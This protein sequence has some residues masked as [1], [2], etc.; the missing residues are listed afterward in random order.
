MEVKFANWYEVSSVERTAYPV[1]AGH[2]DFDVVVVGGGLAGATAALELSRRGKSVALFEATQIGHGASGRNGG[3]VSSGFSETIEV[4]AQTVGIDNAR[5]LMDLS[6]KGAS[7]V[8]TAITEHKMKDVKPVPGWLSVQRHHDEITM[9]TR[10]AFSSEVIGRKLDYWST[11]KVR[12]HLQTERYFQGI[13]D[14][15]GFHIHPLNY[16]IQLVET[17]V[18]SGARVFENDPVIG[19]EKRP[20]GYEVKTDGGVVI[21][22]QLVVTGSAYLQRVFPEIKNL[23][24]PVATHVVVSDHLDAEEVGVISFNGAISDTRRAGD[25]FRLLPNDGKGIRLLWGGKIT[26]NPGPPHNLASTARRDIV[27][28]FPKLRGINIEY[29]WSGLMG[30]TLNKMPMIAEVQPGLWAC[31]GFGGHGINTTAMGG[32]LVARAI[33]NDDDVYRLFAPFIPKRGA[34]P[35]TKMLTQAAYWQMQ[36]RDRRDERR[37]R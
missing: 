6:R 25:Y 17:A 16:L 15:D 36:R 33:A 23:M 28:V 22:G 18:K 5:R 31:T 14:P 3:F 29:A 21:A 35:F 26:T 12:S 11:N 37:K 7:Y 10:A 32:M 9:S 1:F 30:Y 2:A 27:R 34:G 20:N 8:R 4:I 24:L 19:V 13:Y